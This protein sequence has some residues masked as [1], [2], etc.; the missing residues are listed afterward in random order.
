MHDFKKSLKQS[1]ID[2]TAWWWEPVYLQGFPD[3]KRM[4]YEHD[5]EEQLRGIDRKIWLHSGELLTFDEKVR[6]DDYGDFLL[7][8]WSDV[9]RKVKGW[10]R[11]DLA[12]HYIAYVVKPSRL[13][14]FIPFPPLRQALE[15]NRPEWKEKG[16]AGCEGFDKKDSPNKGYVTRNLAVPRKVLMD[17]V[18]GVKVC[19]WT[20]RPRT[21][22]WGAV[23]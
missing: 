23:Q 6:K 19:T 8:I 22:M 15:A 3:L 17:A 13:C 5:L 16:N 4:E 11:K 18:P 10:S 2:A 20:R 12:C 14:F 7:E 1:K 9:E 21:T